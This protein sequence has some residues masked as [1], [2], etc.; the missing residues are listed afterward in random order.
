MWVIKQKKSGEFYL[1]YDRERRLSYNLRGLWEYICPQ[2]STQASYL[3]RVNQE[4]GYLC[5]N[6]DE[7]GVRMLVLE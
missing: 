1:T 5:C 2:D 7:N 3:I 6:D 4:A